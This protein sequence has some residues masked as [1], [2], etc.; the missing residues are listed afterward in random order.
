[1]II[2][3]G[4][5]FQRKYAVI[6]DISTGLQCKKSI[7]FTQSNLYLNC[8]QECDKLFIVLSILNISRL[9]AVLNIN[10]VQAVSVYRPQK[11]LLM[12]DF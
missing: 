10:V 11:C 2:T 6:S 5:L 12:P 4:K 1:M 9:N 3:I 7:I 8:F